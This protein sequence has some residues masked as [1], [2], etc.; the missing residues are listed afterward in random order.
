MYD[1]L[2]S[3]YKYGF[4]IIKNIPTKDNFIVKFANSIGSVEEQTSVNFRH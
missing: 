1:L 4:V 2:I 3:F